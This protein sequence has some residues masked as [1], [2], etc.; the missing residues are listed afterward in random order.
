MRFSLMSSFFLFLDS[1][2]SFS[3]ALS[4][5]LSFLSLQHLLRLFLFFH[6]VFLVYRFLTKP[7]SSLHY[8]FSFLVWSY[9]FLSNMI[10]LAERDF[11]EF[12]L[13]LFLLSFCLKIA[14]K[15]NKLSYYYVMPW[16][17]FVT[18]LNLIV[19][20]LSNCK[21]NWRTNCCSPPLFFC[22]TTLRCE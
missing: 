15:R 21:G 19:F 17:A 2:C 6:S 16:P 10:H 1:L 7:F 3:S 18:H 11:H 12:F 8:L 22:C 4:Y 14:C 5:L 20:F 9:F 13:H